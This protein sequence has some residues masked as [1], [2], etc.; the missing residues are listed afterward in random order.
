MSRIRTTHFEV[1]V[2]QVDLVRDT[3]YDL[4]IYRVVN[5]GRNHVRVFPWGNGAS[6]RCD[7]LDALGDVIRD[8]ITAAVWNVQNEGAS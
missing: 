5:R 8:E 4:V 2:T 1:R 3:E 6:P 7:S